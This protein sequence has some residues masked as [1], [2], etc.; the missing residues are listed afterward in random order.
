MEATV[1]QTP[2][3]EGASWISELEQACRACQQP[4]TGIM[5]DGNP[6]NSHSKNREKHLVFAHTHNCRAAEKMAVILRRKGQIVVSL[7]HRALEAYVGERMEEQQI[8]LVNGILYSILYPDQQ[9]LRNAETMNNS[10]L[11]LICNWWQ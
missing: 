4:A 7:G 9:E 6:L 3:G 2:V 1:V 10:G 8:K 11:N 5:V